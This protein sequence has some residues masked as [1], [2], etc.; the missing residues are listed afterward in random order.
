M[1]VALRRV[2]G[3][4]QHLFLSFRRPVSS[5]HVSQ[6]VRRNRRRSVIGPLSM[7]ENGRI[8]FLRITGYGALN[9]DDRVLARV[10]GVGVPH[11]QCPPGPRSHLP[12]PTGH[13]GT[14][15]HRTVGLSRFCGDS[16]AP[17]PRAVASGAESHRGAS[18]VAQTPWNTLRT[19]LPLN[20]HKNVR[21]SAECRLNGI[22][23]YLRIQ[24]D[25]LCGSGAPP[26][27]AILSSNAPGR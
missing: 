27:A 15:P 13:T 22:Y 10:R 7:W 25:E 9:G 2:V 20:T 6:E 21:G 12:E 3:S 8:Q 11:S 17:H 16:R 5:A 19:I 4:H 14:E 18:A 23:A 24:V 26:Q 1:V